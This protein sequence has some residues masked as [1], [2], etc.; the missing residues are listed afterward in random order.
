MS[1]SVTRYACRWIFSTSVLSSSG[2]PAPSA[3]AYLSDG[4][5]SPGPSSTARKALSRSRAWESSIGVGIRSRVKSRSRARMPRGT[6]AVNTRNNDQ[7]VDDAT[8]PRFVYA[9]SLC[10]ERVLPKRPPS[11]CRDSRTLHWHVE[12]RLRT[13]SS[14][15]RQSGEQALARH[16]E[17]RMPLDEDVEVD[18]IKVPSRRF[19]QPRHVARIDC[20]ADP[21]DELLALARTSR[22]ARAPCD[23]PQALEALSRKVP[24]HR[25]PHAEESL[26]C[27]TL[28]TTEPLAH[29]GEGHRREVQHGLRG[30]QVE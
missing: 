7:T 26:P 17:Q 22:H 11:S 8:R 3:A 14:Q 6:M 25:V 4:S 2:T 16:V 9:N 23:L 18:R 5:V 30:E 13:Q 19:G 24:Q 29:L 20:T 21:V 1:P 28:R 27:S 12:R 15:R 10:Q